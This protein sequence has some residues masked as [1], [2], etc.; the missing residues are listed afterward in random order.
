[1]TSEQ[2]EALRKKWAANGGKTIESSD[3]VEG[4]DPAEFIES[5][6]YSRSEGQEEIPES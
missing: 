3:G 4:F 6:S 1:M 5:L 2:I